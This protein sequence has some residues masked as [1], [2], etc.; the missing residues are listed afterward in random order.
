[1][2]RGNSNTEQLTD[3]QLIESYQSTGEKSVL[4]ILFKRYMPLVYGT[5][6]NYLKDREA[7]KDMAMQVFEKLMRE[8]KE[9]EVQNFKSWLYVLT[10]NE[11]LMLLR[12]KSLE[13]NGVE[14]MEYQLA[15][16]HNNETDL[17]E[18]L[19]KMET[20]IEGLNE[21]QNICIKLFYLEKKTYQEVCEAT[22]FELKKVKSY[23]QNGRRN[24]KICIE[25]L[26]EQEEQ[27][28]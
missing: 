25:K 7:A 6:M 9:K 10:R 11:C 14:L 13:I 27:T 23:L 16:H 19:G 1:M 18:D 8:L 4:G 15:A 12:K 26:R 5:C 20:C 22:G 3:I 21:E 28:Y 2:I 24:L 17:E